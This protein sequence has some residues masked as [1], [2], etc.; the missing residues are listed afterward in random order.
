MI[1]FFNIFDF[2]K[3]KKFVLSIFIY[4][5]IICILIWLFEVF[6]KIPR[7]SVAGISDEL[8]RIKGPYH[9]FFH[10]P[11]Y[12]LQLIICALPLLVETNKTNRTNQ[13]NKTNESNLTFQTLTT[14]MLYLLI[15]ISI[16]I[17]YKSYTKGGWITLP[18]ILF[19][20]FI[21]RKKFIPALLVVV[22]V[23]LFI[24]LN[25]FRSEAGSLFRKEID[26]LILRN[27]KWEPDTLFMGRYRRWKGGM[28]E[29]NN[30]PFINKLLGAEKS[31]KNPENDYLRILWH[32]GIIGL[33][34]FIL[35]LLQSIYLIVRNYIKNK[36]PV[37]LT[38]IFV[39]I[40]YLT[41]AIGSYP[42]FY[43]AFQW[44]L[45]GIVGFVLSEQ[46]AR[47]DSCGIDKKVF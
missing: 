40:M 44:L 15:A 25:P 20:W 31:P 8:T 4:P 27:N 2:K 41:S 39:I 19:L 28:Y 29:F 11:F 18:V 22:G 10:F 7:T 38:G 36:D 37:F 9:D 46:K 6:S 5:A 16:F 42:L 21:L 24:S 13:T 12:G 23:I 33:I 32:N 35:L 47:K 30:M 3:D 26:I 45:W 43:P 17:I 1:L 14:T 34:V